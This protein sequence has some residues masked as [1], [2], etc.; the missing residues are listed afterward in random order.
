LHPATCCGLTG[1]RTA[2]LHTCD[3]FTNTLVWGREA[4]Q[5]LEEG[6]EVIF[7]YKVLFRV[8]CA[9]TEWAL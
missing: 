4:P 1:A 6:E 2:A 3:P 8:R 7:P 9:R 5:T